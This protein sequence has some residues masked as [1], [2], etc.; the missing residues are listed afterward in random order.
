VGHTLFLSKFPAAK[1]KLPG[2]KATAYN[3]EPETKIRR[4]TE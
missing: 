2:R 4:V 3:F 1:M